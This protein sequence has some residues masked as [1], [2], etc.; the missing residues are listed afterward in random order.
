MPATLSK[1]A[2]LGS[3]NDLDFRV[4]SAKLVESQPTG[5]RTLVEV[6]AKNRHGQSVILEAFCFYNGDKPEEKRARTKA[7]NLATLFNS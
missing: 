5:S 2:T 3:Y 7:A 1:P 6:V 4:G